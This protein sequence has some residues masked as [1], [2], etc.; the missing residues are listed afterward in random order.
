MVESIIVKYMKQK[1]TAS[2]NNLL[3]DVSE[4]IEKK[5]FSPNESFIKS[6][7]DELTSRE[8][9]KMTTTQPQEGI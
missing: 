5:G 7:L 8:F 6:C 4:L 3:E 1:K 9:L 2:Y